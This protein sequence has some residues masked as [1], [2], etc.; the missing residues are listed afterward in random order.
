MSEVKALAAGSG[1]EASSKQID[2]VC[3]TTDGVG[4]ARTNGGT[5]VSSASSVSPAAT[6]YTPQPQSELRLGFV[7]LVGIWSQHP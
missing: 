4:D 3:D 7:S 6:R 1:G 5:G 2:R